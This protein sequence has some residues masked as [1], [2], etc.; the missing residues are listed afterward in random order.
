[1]GKFSAL[2]WHYPHVKHVV[3]AALQFSLHPSDIKTCYK[4]P[5]WVPGKPTIAPSGPRAGD[6][7]LTSHPPTLG[8]KGF[9]LRVNASP[10]KGASQG[11]RV[12]DADGS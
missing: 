8:L 1:M 9:E 6:E 11:S 3:E 2:G 7:T 4:P 5:P 12:W 10:A